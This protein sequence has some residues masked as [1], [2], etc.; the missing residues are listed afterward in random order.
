MISKR[1]L[2]VLF[3][4]SLVACAA[5]NSLSAGNA[6]LPVLQNE[7]LQPDYGASA[8][9]GAWLPCGFPPKA[10]HHHPNKHAN[11]AACPVALNVHY[12][13]IR[14]KHFPVADIP[15]LHPSDIVT[16]YAFPSGTGGKTVAIVDAYND[17]TAEKDMNVYRSRFGLPPCSSKSGCFRKVN[18]E[19]IAGKYS[20]ASKAWAQETALDLEMVSAVCPRCPILL[21]EAKSASIDDLGAGVDEAVALGAVAVSNSYYT[22]EWPDETSED[23]HYNHPGVAITASSGDTGAGVQASPYYPAAS[24]YVTAVGATTLT[25]AARTE[26]AW[27]YAGNGCSLYEPQPSFQTGVSCATRSAVDMAVVG[28]PQTGVTIFSTQAGG[29]VVAGGTSVGAPIVAAAYALSGNLAPPSFSYAHRTGFQAIPPASPGG[30][31]AETGLGFP[32]G[33]AGL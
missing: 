17:P 13:G 9:P 30:Y 18:Q 24:P 8:L 11:P 16:L 29:W 19:G 1:L 21:V 32:Y 2:A 26:T 20:H 27:T 28:D 4:L 6:T 10:S 23:V 14:N 33:V 5:Q 25:G 15:G 7:P 3:P 31:D 22:T 12:P